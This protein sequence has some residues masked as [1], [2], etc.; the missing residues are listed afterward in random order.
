VA[1]PTFPNKAAMN[2]QP[3]KE[4]FVHR[5]LDP[6][7]RM[8]EIL[9]GLIMVLSITL[10]AGLTVAEGRAGVRQLLIAALGCNLAW[11]LIDGIMYVMNSMAERSV[12]SRLIR[13]IQSAPSEGAALDMIRNE[14]EPELES[15][16]RP[17]DREIFYRATLKHLAQGGVLRTTLNKD[18][19]YGGLACFLLVFVSCLPVVAPFLIFSEP[20]RALRVSNFLLVAML[21]AV[22]NK[23][24][25][26]A[27]ANRLVVGLSMVA[28][29]LALVGVAVLLEG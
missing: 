14:V 16:A 3:Q 21:F 25:V 2:A 20:T 11:G 22:G 7:S 28:I 9:F 10:T 29:G 24:A 19:L 27:N 17:E 13:E 12:R 18:D 5:Y 8:G 6:A 26:Y 4:R 23:W 1:V 15:L